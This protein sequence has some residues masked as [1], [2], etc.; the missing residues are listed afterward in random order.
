MTQAMKAQSLRESNSSLVLHTILQAS[1]PIS[2]A[3]VASKTGLTRATVSRLVEDFQ[4][5]GILDELAPA[6]SAGGRPSVPLV[7]RANAVFSISLELN[8][9]YMAVLV[10]DLSGNIAHLNI[11][12]RNLRGSQPESVFHQL[13]LLLREWQPPKGALIISTTLV[14]PGLVDQDHTSIAVAP[15][16]G[17]SNVDPREFMD[18]PAYCGTLR[19]Q[20]EADA[21]AFASIYEAPGRQNENT[22]FLYISSDVGIGSA[23]MLDGALFR[24]KH[25]WAGEIG[26]TCVDPSGPKCSC[27]SNGCLEQYAGQDAL[28]EAANLSLDSPINDLIDL[29]V[30]GDDI[31]RH[32]LDRAATSLGRAIA[33]ALN[34]LDVDTVILGG[35][36]AQLLPYFEVILNSEVNYRQLSS[37][38][39]ETQ[40]VADQHGQRAACLGACFAAFEDF[41]QRPHEWLA[42]VDN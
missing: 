40:I 37:Q 32:V 9:N 21:A 12:E 16:L 41:I 28:M 42:A 15:N 35:N 38:W 36:F 7:P 3:D 25:F 19:L 33:N 18:L 2:R 22:T 23:I 20:N 31:A 27:G 14:I 11:E 34:L 13:G 30:A 24:G 29:F 17:W 1:N 8:V 39:V 10:L 5:A 6:K 26:H 4:T